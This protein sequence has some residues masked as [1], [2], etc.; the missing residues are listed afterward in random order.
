[1]KKI[2]IGLS[3]SSAPILGIRLLEILKD[4]TKVETHLVMSPHLQKT[5][6]SEAPDY[7]L[8][9][10]KKLADYVYPIQEVGAP[11][12]S[13]SFKAHAMVICPC[14]MN[15]LGAIANGLGANL[16]TRAADVTLKERRPLILVPRE[17]PLNL[18]HLRNMVSV[19]EMGGVILPP[20]LAFYHQPKT[21]MD[22]VDHTV[23]K[24]LD[25]LGIEKNLFKRWEGQKQGS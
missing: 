13:G 3:S 8:E 18:A 1:M 9:D 22:L 6:L 19:T 5:L 21:V 7:T 17:T 12:A 4:E 16:M 25:L 20:A 10:L 23:G 24:V 15:T 2:I 11:I 14:S